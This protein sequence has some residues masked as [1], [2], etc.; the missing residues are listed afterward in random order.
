MTPQ[1]HAL[2]AAVHALRNGGLVAFPTETV[3]GLGADATQE[4]AIRALFERKGRPADHPLIVHIA[5]V[6]DM[7]DWADP[8][9]EVVLQLADAFSPGPLTF[10][11]PKASHVSPLL[12]GG[13]ET[14]GLRIP[15]HPHAQA[16]LQAFDGGV[17][18]PSAN[19]FGRVSA[20]TAEAV[21]AEFGDTIDV[22]LD[23]G[24]C[25]IGIESTIVDCTTSPLT[26]LRHGAV[27]KE[28]LTAV[29]GAPPN[30]PSGPV[31]APGMLAS[32]YAP[33]CR[34]RIVHS[35]EEA[36]RYL[37]VA[38]HQSDFYCPGP[39]LIRYAQ[40]LYEA[41]RDADR[42]GLDE[43]VVVRPPHVGL[44]VAINE[45]L[46]KAAAPRPPNH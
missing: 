16:L 9:P 12:T 23:G 36:A 24:S 7:A 19:R 8:I 14:I 3:Y 1:E 27:T 42:R 22:V 20:T 26:I 30:E 34:I 5:S 11:V 4:P 44:G 38:T 41:F 39:D 15:A 31:R 29:L 13:R 21:Y 28:M 10:L 17:A 2:K 6:D 43:L 33:R 32:H 46:E 25:S 37:N 45:R 40:S 35:L 18:A